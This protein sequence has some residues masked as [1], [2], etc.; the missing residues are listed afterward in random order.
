MRSWLRSPRS[1]VVGL[2]GFVLPGAGAETVPEPIWVDR[3]PVRPGG[4]LIYDEGRVELHPKVLLG[5]GYDSNIDAVPT[6]GDQ[7]FYARGLAGV[8]LH[9]LPLLADRFSLDGQIDAKRYHERGDRDFTGGR[10]RLGWTRESALGP[11]AAVLLDGMLVDDP[12]IE[13]GRQVQRA[14][15]EG[16][17]NAWWRGSNNVFRLEAG[18]VGEDFLEDAGAFDQD[19]R[20]Y[21]RPRLIGEWWYGRSDAA[22]RLG[23]RVGADRIIYR[24]DGSDYQD[25]SGLAVVF[26]VTHFFSSSLQVNGHIGV[27]HRIYDDDFAEDPAHDDQVITRPI[28]QLVLRWDPEEYSRV[29]VGVASLVV[30]TIGSNAAYLM[31]TW[32]HARWRLLRSFGVLGEADLISV[33][34]SGTSDGDPPL[35]FTIRLRV[36]AELWARDG[37]AI[38]LLGGTDTGEPEGRDGYDRVIATLD[39][40]FA[41]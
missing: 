5:V 9:W 1:L 29:D 39:T 17:A 37:I 22:T 26:L 10:L 30:P 19:E 24:Q 27:E 33:E 3:V 14:R 7:D 18:M 2:L 16:Q 36:G 34:R 31:Q 32:V 15:H 40:V 23:A 13:T 38:R 25:G 35:D 6:G 20:D 28:G 4:N 11:V 12:L 21:L 8:L 41:W